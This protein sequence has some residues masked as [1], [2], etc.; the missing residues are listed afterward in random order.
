MHDPRSA[1]PPPKVTVVT[2][3][4]NV[5][6]YIGE[7]VDSV[8][9]QSFRD[10]EYLVI[11]DGSVDN[12]VAVVRAH[13]AGDRRVRIIQAEH[14][15]LS[16]V[17]NLGIRESRATYIAYLDGD[18]RWRPRFLERQIALIESVPSN[19]GAVF[20][21]SR[22]MLENGTFVFLQSQ[23]AGSYD[24]D[25]FLVGNNPAR[26]GSSLLIRKSCFEDVGGF[27]EGV[28]VEDLE[29]WLRIASDSK[30]PLFWASRDYLVDLRLRPGQL[31][32]DRLAVAKALDDLLAQQ[33]GKLRRLPAGLAYVRPAMTALKYGG[34]DELAEEWV[35]QAKSAGV[36]RL[37]REPTGLRLLFWH[38]LT[39]VGRSR[40][41]SLQEATRELVKRANL[42][43]LGRA[44]AD[45]AATQR[46]SA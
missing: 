46:E 2:P 40:L 16:A 27:D 31:T 43:L 18:D 7:T 11:D 22:V 32:R 14:C 30:T 21:R 38:S 10:F 33:T 25:D 39:P 24:F 20:C 19:V 35:R 44:E 28:Y 17:R 9:R 4:Y 13:A 12:S 8:L 26:N 29:M 15:G 23:R 36:A 42:R 34:C 5:A 41:R 37:V 3:A 1:A 45:S 6:K